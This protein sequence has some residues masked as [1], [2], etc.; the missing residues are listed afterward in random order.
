MAVP[1]D[2]LIVQGQR[3]DISVVALLQHFIQTPYSEV[4]LCVSLPVL[5]PP[6]EEL[7]EAS[8]EEYGDCWPVHLLLE[9]LQRLIGTRL[10]QAVLLGRQLYHIGN[11]DTLT[12]HPTP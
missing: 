2:E 6:S 5:L 8:S 12:T 11:A 9:R 10:V 4:Y 3:D 7:V 1:V